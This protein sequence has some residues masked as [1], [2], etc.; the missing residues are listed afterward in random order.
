METLTKQQ[1]DLLNDNQKNDFQD[2]ICKK[3]INEIYPSWGDI[4]LFLLKREIIRGSLGDT[5][6]PPAMEKL[7][8]LWKKVLNY[9]NKK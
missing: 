2:E 4:H 6:T 3:Y 5:E 1:W 7:N 8:I 9:Y